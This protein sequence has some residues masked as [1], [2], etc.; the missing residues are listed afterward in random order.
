MALVDSS[1]NDVQLRSIEYK[2]SDENALEDFIN[3]EANSKCIEFIKLTSRKSKSTGNQIHKKTIDGSEYSFERTDV[4]TCSRNGDKEK[5][6]LLYF[7]AYEK[8]VE[9]AIFTSF[10]KAMA[11]KYHMLVCL[12]GTHKTN[13]YDYNLFTLVTQYKH[14]QGIPIAYLISSDGCEATLIKFLQ[15]FKTYCPVV[16]AFMT[17]CCKAEK[18]AVET[19]YPNSRHILCYWHVLKA[20]T[21]KLKQ[22]RNFPK[23]DPF[24]LKL[25]GLLHSRGDFEKEYLKIVSIAS[26][27]FA[28]YL[29]VYWYENKEKWA[30]SFRH[31]IPMFKFSNTNML[32]ESFH[33][34]L[35]THFLKQKVN[36]RVDRLIFKLT[37]ELEEHYIDRINLN[38]YDRFERIKFNSQS[39]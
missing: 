29:N 37:G 33:N 2:F 25:K 34:I 19:V 32:I 13:M 3:H 6:D 7:N 22:E 18:T 17:D 11:E 12:D 5:G 31:N 15:A 39:F 10:G 35:K 8:K 14:Q 27:E 20:W 36:R 1:Q 9:I 23:D 28:S 16:G 26:P 21:Q 30:F 4:W 24:W 38:E